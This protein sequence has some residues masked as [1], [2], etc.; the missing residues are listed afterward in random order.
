MIYNA[1]AYLHINNRQLSVIPV[2]AEF[3]YLGAVF[4]TTGLAKISYQ[5]LKGNLD[6]VIC[7]PAKHQQRLF[8]LKNFLLP[9]F[10][11]SFIFAKLYSGHLKKIDIMVPKT[12]R[13]ILYLPHDLP[14]A[15]FHAK[16]ADGGMVFLRY[17][18]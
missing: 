14:K 1:N 6:R 16:V 10:Y 5:K 17:D 12:V 2:N 8:K 11:H 13:K 7:S 3:K 18:T 4:T 15:A 9:Q